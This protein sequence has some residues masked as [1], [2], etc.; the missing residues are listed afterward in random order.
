MRDSDLRLILKISDTKSGT[1]HKHTEEI[2]N[3]PSVFFNKNP[4]V[5]TKIHVTFRLYISFRFM[6]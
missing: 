2:R 1:I 5:G 6:F 3:D 4:Q